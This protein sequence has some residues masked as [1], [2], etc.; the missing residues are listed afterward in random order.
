MLKAFP[1]YTQPTTEETEIPFPD[2]F[3]ILGIYLGQL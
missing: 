2:F 1:S 3:L